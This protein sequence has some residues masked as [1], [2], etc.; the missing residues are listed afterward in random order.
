MEQL[1]QR[2]K[3][4]KTKRNVVQRVEEEVMEEEAE[5]EEEEFHPRRP[6]GLD[7]DPLPDYPTDLLID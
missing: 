2:D 1:K 3:S 7:H 5:E 4:P 6:P